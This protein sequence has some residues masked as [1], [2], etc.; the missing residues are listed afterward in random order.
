MSTLSGLAFFIIYEYFVITLINTKQAGTY[1]PRLNRSFEIDY[2]ND[3]FRMNGQ[4]FRYISG[5]FHYFRAL[6]QRWRKQFKAMRAAGLNAIQ[7]LVK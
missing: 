2:E 5:S 4:P 3:Q 6:P 7:T 1:S